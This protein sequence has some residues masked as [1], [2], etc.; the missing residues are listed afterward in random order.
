MKKETLQEIVLG[1]VGGLVFAMGMCMCLIS[2]WNLFQSGV[3]TSVV[4]LAILLLIIPVYRKT[5]P[6][7]PHGPVNWGIVLAWVIG[8][9]GA[10]LMGFGMSRVMQGS[11]SQSDFFLGLA[12]GVAGMIVCVL[13]YPV[14]SYFSNK[15]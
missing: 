6:R 3:I 11:P 7:K 10:L 2:E 8:I 12:C 15:N 9:A 14:Y 1:T 5:H 13:V 4:G